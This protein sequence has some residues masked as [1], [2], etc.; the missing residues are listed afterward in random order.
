[1]KKNSRNP[2]TKKDNLLEKFSAHLIVFKW[3]DKPNEKTQIK[4]DKTI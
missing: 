2:F 1:M 4:L 3:T